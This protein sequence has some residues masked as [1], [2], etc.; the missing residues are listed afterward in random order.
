MISPNWMS[1]KGE[2]EFEVRRL[3]QQEVTPSGQAIWDLRGLTN[4]EARRFWQIFFS[5]V[6]SQ[7]TVLETASLL[8]YLVWAACTALV[9]GCGMGCMVD[10]KKA[11]ALGSSC[12]GG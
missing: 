9:P 12:L 8:I 3:G 7:T 2:E 6:V 5:R 11:L 10:G 1:R 4:P